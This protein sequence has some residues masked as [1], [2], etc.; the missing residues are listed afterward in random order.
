[1]WSKRLDVIVLITLP[2]LAAFLTIT[3]RTGLFESVLM[4]FGIPAGYLALRNYGILKKSFVFAFI[5]SLPL[6]LFVDVLAA[7]NGSWVIQ[8]SIFPFRFWGVASVEVYLFGLLWVL[9]V[10]LFYEH[11]CDGGRKGDTLS[12]RAILLVGLSVALVFYTVSA[13]LFRDELLH[14][15]FFYAVVGI[16]LVVIPLIFFL[17]F[18]PF[19]WRRFLLVGIYFFYL[20]LLFELV[21]LATEQWI[22]P[23]SDFVGI[24]LL[25]GFQVP[26]EEIVIWMLFSTASLL[27]YYEFLGDDRSLGH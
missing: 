23:G 4:F 24:F 6:S 26:I 10:V 15:P 12:K 20:L 8:T 27:A 1:M 25:V 19:F 3:F 11:F 7:I 14:I 5:L 2:T 13:F 17:L 21:A 16:V 22:F 18:Y 9:F